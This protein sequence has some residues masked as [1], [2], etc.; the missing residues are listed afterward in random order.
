MRIISEA[1]LLTLAAV[2]TIGELDEEGS[3]NSIQLAGL[4]AIPPRRIEKQLQ[5][6][7]HAT[8]LHSIRG[9]RGGY[10]LAPGQSLDRLNALTIAKVIAPAS[11]ARRMGFGAVDIDAINKTLSSS[12]EQLLAATSLIEFVT[13]PRRRAA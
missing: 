8:I 10:I 4:L 1:L 3:I 11:T 2:I 9:P 12:L 7:C 5:A 13:E 6:L